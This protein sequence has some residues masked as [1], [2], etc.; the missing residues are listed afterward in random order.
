MNANEKENEMTSRVDLDYVLTRLKNIVEQS[1]DRKKDLNGFIQECE[2]NLTVKEPLVDVTEDAE[3]IVVTGDWFIDGEKQPQEILAR[4]PFHCGYNFS[5]YHDP[6]K[7]E[8]LS[9]FITTVL[10]TASCIRS[11]YEHFPDIPV[12]VQ[13]RFSFTHVNV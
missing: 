2:H 3:I 10:T 9:S 4:L 11:C 8:D 7:D 12:H 13:V 6:I 1:K 5:M